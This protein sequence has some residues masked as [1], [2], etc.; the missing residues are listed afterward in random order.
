ML[1]QQRPRCAAVAPAPSVHWGTHGWGHLEGSWYNNNNNCKQ[2]WS[3]P[4]LNN[5]NKI[6]NP[7]L[8]LC[9]N[10]E[11]SPG[12]SEQKQCRARQ[13]TFPLPESA[14]VTCVCNAR[15]YMSNPGTVNMAFG[16]GI[17]KLSLCCFVF[18]LKCDLKEIVTAYWQNGLTIAQLQCWERGSVLLSES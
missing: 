3:N 8:R 12:A 14:W 1:H 18:S 13:Q 4:N 7:G 9:C 6:K 15:C 17:K 16:R 2:T 5:C 10:A 11:A